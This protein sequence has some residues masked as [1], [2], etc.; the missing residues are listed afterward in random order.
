MFNDVDW[1]FYKQV[2]DRVQSRRTFV[3]YYKGRLEVVTT[4]LL[5]ESIS[6]LL[7]IMVWVLAEE[8]DVGMMSSGRTT[9]RRE[10]LDSGTEPDDSFYII[11]EPIM[12]GRKE[13]N[14]PADPPPDLAIEVE[15]TRRLGE[16]RSVY[17]DLNVPEIWIFWS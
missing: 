9:L 1:A 3:T 17:Q 8:L 4:S 15:V 7:S 6:K 11:N 5:H 2:N 16:R 13:I 12:R 10:D 14:L